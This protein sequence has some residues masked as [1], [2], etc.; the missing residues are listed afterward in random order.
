MG[1]VYRARQ[2]NL[3]RIVALKTVLHGEYASPEARRRFRIEAEAVAR[4][5]HPNIVQIF[6]IGEHDGR[7][8]FAL[9]YCS[10]GSLDARISGKPV[11]PSEAAHLVELLAR[12]VQAI[13]EHQLVHRDLKPANVLLT[14]DGQPKITDFGLARRLDQNRQTQSGAVMGTPCYMAPEQARG[15]TKDVGP[16]A[17]IYALGAILY[18]CL[19]ARPPFF[20]KSSFDTMKE[21]LEKEPIHPRSFNRHIDRDLEI[22]C[23]KCLEKAPSNRYG[24][25]AE[26]AEDLHR[27]QAGEP[28]RAR[29]V[30][31]LERLGRRLKQHPVTIV[32][33]AILGLGLLWLWALAARPPLNTSAVTGPSTTIAAPPIAAPLPGRQHALLI[34]VNEYQDAP[35]IG[36]TTGLAQADRDAVRIGRA[37]CVNGHAPENVSV[38]STNEPVSERLYPSAEH[39][40]QQLHRIVSLLEEP[41]SVLVF[42]AG[43]ELQFPGSDEYFIC[44]A[45]AKRQDR[46]TLIS[47]SEIGDELARAKAKCKIVIVDS[48]RLLEREG[49]ER[50][51]T[52]KSPPKGVAILFGCSAGENAYEEQDK[53]AGLFSYCLW[54]GLQG[55]ADL[56]KDGKITWPELVSYLRRQVPECAGRY[57]LHQLPEAIGETGELEIRLKK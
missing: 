21:V 40:R 39:I 23:L 28:I 24:S 50:A 1:V 38:M 46:T 34:G 47:L 10:G 16:A 55:A 27:F 8:Y 53:K 33:A 32:L 56:N 36:R 57:G 26:L 41:D 6:D 2:I 51:A 44:P 13:H 29:P 52:P 31:L 18:Q 17:D 22:I 9:E 43:Y 14:A 12:A 15:D 45:D 54:E 48:C 30:N 7:L 35:A 20:A 49:T 19:T 4:L 5:Q 25:A 37:L 42:F 3:G 11:T